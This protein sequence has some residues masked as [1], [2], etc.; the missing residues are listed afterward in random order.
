MPPLPLLSELKTYSLAVVHCYFLTIICA[1]IL[2]CI[3]KRTHATPRHPVFCIFLSLPIRNYYTS[4]ALMIPYS[5][6]GSFWCNG[7]LDYRNIRQNSSNT[8]WALDI[9]FSCFLIIRNS[10]IRISNIRHNT[11]AKSL[12]TERLEVSIL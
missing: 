3:P 6:F 5:N 2:D 7:F 8:F 11:G 9:A 10:I 1:V 4:W 12:Y